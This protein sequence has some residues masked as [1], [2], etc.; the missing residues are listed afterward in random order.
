M[1]YPAGWETMFTAKNGGSLRFR[2]ERASDTEMLWSMFSTLSENSGSNLIP[3]FT[4]QRIESW[5]NNIDYTQ[6]VAVVAVTEEAETQRIVG[7]AS[8]KFHTDE[9]FKH[10]AELGLTVHDDYQN[11]GHRNRAAKSHAQHR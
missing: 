5:T 9:V 6:V 8:L 1:A 3:P 10:K 2:P 4:R 7:S 11:L